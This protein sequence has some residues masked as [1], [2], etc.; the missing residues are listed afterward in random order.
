MP[1][2]ECNFVFCVLQAS[3]QESNSQ[4]ATEFVEHLAACIMNSFDVD[5]DGQISFEEFVVSQNCS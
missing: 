1:L 5:R 2:A 4:M 3:A